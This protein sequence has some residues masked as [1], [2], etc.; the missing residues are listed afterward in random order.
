LI[1]AFTKNTKETIWSLQPVFVTGRNTDD[2]RIFIMPATGPSSAF[3]I[4]LSDYLL[5]TFETGDKRKAVWT[6]SVT[7][8]GGKTYYYPYKYKINANNQTVNEYPIV[9]RL[10]EQY[11]IRAEARAQLV[12]IP[13]SQADLNVIRKR[14]GLLNTTASTK[15]LLLPAIEKERQ[16]ELFSEWGHRWFDLKRTGK[17]DT[18]MSVVTPKKGGVWKTEWQWYPLPVNEI[19]VNDHLLQNLGYEK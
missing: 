11:L 6:G 13:E 17:V 12:K 8:T 3:P 2:A 9:F 4:F 10:S 18:V 14:A 5:N 7:P 15:E 16:V 1:N 19:L